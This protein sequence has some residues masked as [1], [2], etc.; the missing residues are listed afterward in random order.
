MQFLQ[1]QLFNRLP[2]STSYYIYLYKDIFSILNNLRWAHAS[3]QVCCFCAF[4]AFS[5]PLAILFAAPHHQLV[6]RNFLP[7]SYAGG[8]LLYLYAFHGA[9]T[10]LEDVVVLPVRYH[11]GSKRFFPLFVAI[12]LILAFAM[13][14]GVYPLTLPLLIDYQRLVR[15][16]LFFG[17]SLLLCFISCESR[18]G[19]FI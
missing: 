5:S 1:V 12:S 17:F 11:N 15:I 7:L 16:L 13:S 10:C 4:I 18:N 9:F 3:P 2:V 19:S 14:L 8:Q 6:G